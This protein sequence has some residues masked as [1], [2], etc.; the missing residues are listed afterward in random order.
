MAQEEGCI[1]REERPPRVGQNRRL[2]SSN[3]YQASYVGPDLRHH[4]APNTF[5][6]KMAAERRLIELDAW[7][8]P[9]RA[10]G[11]EESAVD[12]AG[13]VRADLDRSAPHQAGH[14]DRLPRCSTTTSPTRW[15]GIIPLI[16]R[17]PSALGGWGREY[18]TGGGS[19]TFT[20]SLGRMMPGRSTQ[21][22]SPRFF[23]AA[24][25]KWLASFSRSGWWAP[26]TLPGPVHG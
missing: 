24:F 8:P 17:L 19:T 25:T 14:P 6:A 18:V 15:A 22:T 21:P 13:G 9:A 3:R 5:T 20:V 23:H 2:P 1:S 10:G 11:A 12:P 16:L 26:M 4:N 7:I